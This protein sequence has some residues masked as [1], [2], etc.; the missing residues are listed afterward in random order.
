MKKSMLF[1]SLM[2]SAPYIMAN[3]LSSCPNKS[4][5]NYQQGGYTTPD[6]K[7]FGASVG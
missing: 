6:G 5:I 1:L 4:E 3:E 2:L 7:W